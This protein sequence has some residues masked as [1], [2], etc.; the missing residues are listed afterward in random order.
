M[1]LLSNNKKKNTLLISMISLS[2]FFLLWELLLT[3]FP[4][5]ETIIIKPSQI[6]KASITDY[7]IIGRELIYTITEIIPGW[8]LG[9]IIGFLSAILLYKRKN[10]SKIFV[11]S[12]VIL[13]AIPL[14]ALSAIIGGIMG[15]GRDSK[16]LIISIISFFP[17][18]I[19]TLQEFTNIQ[20]NHLDLMNSYSSSKKDL[21]KKIVLPKSLPSVMNTLKVGVITAIFTAISSEFFG[22]YGGIGI[23]ILTKKGLYNL[24]L[25]WASI[26]YVTLFGSIFYFTLELFQKRFIGWKHT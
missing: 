17:M 13:N 2:T 12:S 1:K 3:L 21:F 18:F 10:I 4:V 5:S 14:I 16:I 19:I 20:E 9:N 11:N 25:V 22:G 24:E 6:L 23:F 26:L 8:F 7:D 15:L